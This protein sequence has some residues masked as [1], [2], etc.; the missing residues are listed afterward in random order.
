MSEQDKKRLAILFGIENIEN[1]EDGAVVA[2]S[3][4]MVNGCAG[5]P[6]LIQHMIYNMHKMKIENPKL[7]SKIHKMLKT[8]LAVNGKFQRMDGKGFLF[9]IPAPTKTCSPLHLA[10][11]DEQP[12]ELI[13]ELIRYG[14]SPNADTSYDA[15]V[16]GLLPEQKSSF[17]S[18]LDDFKKSMG[19]KNKKNSEFLFR[20]TTLAII[21]DRTDL[22]DSNLLHFEQ[23]LDLLSKLCKEEQEG[24]FVDF[25]DEVFLKIDKKEV[26]QKL[27]SNLVKPSLAGA[28][29]AGVV[30]L[31]VDKSIRREDCGELILPILNRNNDGTFNLSIS[32][33]K[34]H[35]VD[36]FNYPWWEYRISIN[37]ADREFF[38]ELFSDVGDIEVKKNLTPEL[39]SFLENQG[40]D[41]DKILQLNIGNRITLGTVEKKEFIRKSC[42]WMTLLSEN[43]LKFVELCLHHKIMVPSNHCE[44]DSKNISLLELVLKFGSPEMINLVISQT[45]QIQLQDLDIDRP[46]SIIQYRPHFKLLLSK[47]DKSLEETINLDLQVQEKEAAEAAHLERVRQAKKIQMAREAELDKTTRFP[48]E[49]PS[50]STMSSGNGADMV[51][52]Y[53]SGYPEVPKMNQSL[54]GNTNKKKGFGWF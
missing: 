18:K 27:N 20:A 19:Q 51:F 38:N 5:D 48:A 22:L 26:F 35:G 12:K 49:E 42:T 34:D 29:L 52:K 17:L 39:L 28:S 13:E 54:L 30:T 23:D 11:M 31:V 1:V 47:A 32:R 50:F 21:Y 7:S 16:K 40:L 36:S 44:F 33:C 3:H 9:N 8:L 41:Q 53:G 37:G 24:R 15:L 25:V 4:K 46:E 43:N 45:D 6:E 2:E 10:L 14:C